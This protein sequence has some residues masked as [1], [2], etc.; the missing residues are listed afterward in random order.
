VGRRS[1]E[2]R[3]LRA[4]LAKMGRTSAAMRSGITSNAAR[5]SSVPA[6]APPMAPAPDAIAQLEAFQSED[7]KVSDV[8]ARTAS[9][10][11]SAAGL[12]LALVGCAPS[13]A[14]PTNAADTA[15]DTAVREGG[16]SATGAPTPDAHGDIDRAEGGGYLNNCTWNYPGT[17]VAVIC[18][19]GAMCALNTDRT[20]GGPS[21]GPYCGTTTLPPNCGQIYCPPGWTCDDVPRGLCSTTAPP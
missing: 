10:F 12:T 7:V 9:R 8:T 20:D 13:G 2:H 4:R 15:A 16:D 19:A 3:W 17:A 6:T 1:I 18:D 5:K 21:P 11:V 14:P